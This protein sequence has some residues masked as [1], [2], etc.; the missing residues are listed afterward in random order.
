M[1]FM[2]FRR[3]EMITYEYECK[4]EVCKNVFEFKQRIND[5]RLKECP[6]CNGEVQRLIS[7]NTSFILNGEGWAKDLYHKS[8]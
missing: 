5:E 7:S 2:R 6:I 8:T 4:N 1:I 3:F